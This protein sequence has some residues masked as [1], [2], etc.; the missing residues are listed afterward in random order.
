MDETELNKLQEEFI[1]DAFFRS[2]W[3]DTSQHVKIYEKE[4]DENTKKQFRAFLKERS[5]EIVKLY[6][7]KDEKIDHQELLVKFHKEVTE[8]S[9]FKGKIKFKFG[10]A[11][12]LI[13]VL[14]KYYWCAGKLKQ[15][16]AHM[17]LDRYILKELDIKDV[18]WTQMD[19]K[20]Y[21]VYIK[22]AREKAK[23][24]SLAE[25]ELKTFTSKNDEGAPKN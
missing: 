25:W 14:L 2:A 4:A 6:Q 12:K 13:N 21:E 18:A 11:Q 10:R 16:P 15:E 22:I 23:G 19:D 20:K 5:Y 17:P 9:E 7:D 24:M 1:K 8:K 3:L